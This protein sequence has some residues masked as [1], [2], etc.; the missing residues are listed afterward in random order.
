MKELLSGL[1][2]AEAREKPSCDPP[3]LL[4][5]TNKDYKRDVAL[6]FNKYIFFYVVL[7]LLQRSIIIFWVNFCLLATACG[8]C[9]CL[10]W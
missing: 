4:A 7:A 8:P 10:N 3:S 5:T 9:F 2:G 6:N 1:I